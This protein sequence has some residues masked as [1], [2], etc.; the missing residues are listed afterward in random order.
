[1]MPAPS[2]NAPAPSVDIQIAATLWANQPLA[3]DIV[4]D[5]V[6][7]AAEAIAAPD[8]EVSVVLTD[9]ASIAKLNRDWHRQA[10]QCFVVSGRQNTGWRRHARRHRY[11]L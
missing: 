9:D 4:R 10:D 6:A 2:R 1:M 8:G 7:A 3:E 11:R 5:A